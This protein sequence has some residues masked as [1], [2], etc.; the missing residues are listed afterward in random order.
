V[1]QID[2]RKALLIVHPLQEAAQGSAEQIS[3]WFHSQGVE[4]D[5]LNLAEHPES[6]D[7]E[8]N[9][10]ADVDLAVSLGGD[11]CM[12][13]S[14]LLVGDAD[15][16]VLGVNY[17]RLGYLTEV[18]SEEALGALEKIQSGN[19]ALQERMRL[20]VVLER[21]DGTKAKLGDVLNEA[22][23][24]KQQSGH[25][26]QLSVW[27]DGEFFTTYVADGI[28]IATPTGSTAYSMSARGPIVAPSNEAILFTPVSPHMIFDRPLILPP[29]ATI[30]LEVLPNRI[31]Q[32]ATDGRRQPDLYPGDSLICRRSAHP[33]R[34]VA[35]SERLFFEV[36][37]QKFDLN[38][39][40][41]SSYDG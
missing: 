12:L 15:V 21:A 9:N 1:P 5:T 36:L 14:V 25:T 37:K 22:V 29:D 40:L 17:G 35:F 31:A 34:L 33:A 20:S 3:Q 6:A 27:V 41:G 2:L 28:I 26:V 16:P 10:L 23:L 8:I 4:V 18:E 32:T 13:R 11:G 19:Y 7:L 39:R 24:E 38:D 30:R